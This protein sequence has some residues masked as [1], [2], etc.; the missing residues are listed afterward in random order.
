MRDIMTIFLE[1]FTAVKS[2]LKLTVGTKNSHR[3]PVMFHIASHNDSSDIT[4]NNNTLC[5]NLAG[6][7]F[8]SLNKLKT[9]GGERRKLSAAVIFV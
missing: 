2:I 4:V 6:H 9:S 8:L 3:P 1:H 5:G 7:R